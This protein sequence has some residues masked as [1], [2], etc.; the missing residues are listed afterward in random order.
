MKWGW[1][2]FAISAPCNHGN[3]AW[4][5]HGPQKLQLWQPWI[6]PS[7]GSFED[8]DPP[9]SWYWLVLY[10]DLSF[11]PLKIKIDIMDILSGYFQPLNKSEFSAHTFENTVFQGVLLAWFGWEK[12]W[13]NMKHQKYPEAPTVRTG[14][15]GYAICCWFPFNHFWGHW[16]STAF[17]TKQAD[18]MVISCNIM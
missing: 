5:R 9:A 16:M 1:T 15:S 12:S 2:I 3:L 13:N 17:T 6:C 18:T 14:L 4:L 10:E 8:F 7:P 11:Q